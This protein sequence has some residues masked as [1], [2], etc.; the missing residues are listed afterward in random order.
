METVAEAS[1][2]ASLMPSPTISTRRPDAFSSVRVLALSVGEHAERHSLMPERAAV[3]STAG[4]RSPERS[5]TERPRRFSAA[6]VCAASERNASSK[7]KTTG[8]A[9]PILSHISA[10]REPS[11]STEAPTQS[12]RPSRAISP[13]IPPS[14]PK[15]GTSRMYDRSAGSTPRSA[16]A[17][18]RPRASG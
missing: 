9:L 5:R 11:S 2:G 7:R 10:E 17:L 18:D 3:A 15:P 6:I 4:A 14:M 8:G 12:R 16:A 13:P 1:A